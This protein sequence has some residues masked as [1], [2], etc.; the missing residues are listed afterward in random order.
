MRAY[1]TDIGFLASP[2]GPREIYYTG[3]MMADN[4]RSMGLRNGH[5]SYNHDNCTA[6]FKDSWISAIA[7]PNCDYCYGPTAT[8]CSNNH[9]LRML[10]STINGEKL[11]EKFGTG[12]D[13]VCNQ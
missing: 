4:G 3:Y 8:P 11:P 5:A 2:P 9:G 7:R 10:T 1:A 13:V 12:F 6:T